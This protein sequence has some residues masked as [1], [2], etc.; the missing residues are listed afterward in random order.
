MDLLCTSRD[1]LRRNSLGWRCTRRVAPRCT[2]CT[3]ACT[4]WRDR[5][6]NLMGYWHRIV[7]CNLQLRVV[8]CRRFVW[9]RRSD[10]K[11]PNEKRQSRNPPK[12]LNLPFRRACQCWKSSCWCRLRAIWTLPVSRPLGQR[13]LFRAVLLLYRCFPRLSSRI[14]LEKRGRPARIAK[15]KDRTGIWGYASL[16]LLRFRKIDTHAC[17]YWTHLE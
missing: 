15:R 7:I 16:L 1:L 13:R 6:S 12:T 3:R 5:L 4:C 9:R 2:G 8:R 14:L 11:K 10:R 17:P